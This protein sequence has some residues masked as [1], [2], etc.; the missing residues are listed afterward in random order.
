MSPIEIEDD[1]DVRE[2]LCYQFEHS[3]KFT[4]LFIETMQ[5]INTTIYVDSVAEEYGVEFKCNPSPLEVVVSNDQLPDPPQTSNVVTNQVSGARDI[6][7]NYEYM[8]LPLAST[9]DLPSSSTIP[10]TC[11]S[12]IPLRDLPK[13]SNLISRQVLT[14]FDDAAFTNAKMLEYTDSL[15]EPINIVVGQTFKD[16]SQCQYALSQ[17]A[18]SN[19]F[20]YRVIY[21]NARRFT[22]VCLKDTCEWRVH[23]SRVNDTGIFKIRSYTSKHTCGI[24]LMKS[25][26][27]YSKA[28]RAWELALN[29]VMGSYEDSYNQLPLYLHELR[30]ANPGI[31]TVVLVNQQTCRFERCFIARTMH[32]KF[33]KI[34]AKVAFDIG[35][36]ENNSSWNWLLTYLNDVLG[37]VEGLVIIFNRHK[38]L[39]KEVPQVFPC[40]IHGYYEYHIYRNLVDTFKDKSLEMYYWRAVKTCRSTEF[41]KLMHDIKMTNPPVHAWLTEIGFER[42][43]SSHER[44]F[45]LVTTNISECINAIFKEAREYAVTKLIEV[46]IFKIHELF[47]KKRESA[48]SFVGPLTPW[49]EKQLK[50][51]MQKAGDVRRDTIFRDEYYVEIITIQ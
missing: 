30:T 2:F 40:A 50:D 1:D 42:W 41:E 24:T 43:A 23:A 29:H 22:V 9:T 39:M 10:S 48:A 18:S 38:G 17:F 4:P 27:C 5:H 31:V 34:I 20:Q 12:D 26:H 28:W 36:S 32:L 37:S 16:K 46:V 51:L 3:D 15:C 7:N 47:Y 6:N 49:V 8:T 33:S 44:R 25:D 11:V 35:E 21:S 19:N 13:T 14:S 45:N